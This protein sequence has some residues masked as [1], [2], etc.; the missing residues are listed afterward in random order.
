MHYRHLRK[1]VKYHDLSK[2]KV[3]ISREGKVLYSLPKEDFEI[4]YFIRQGKRVIEN[5]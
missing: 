1:G 5:R 2:T 4:H 3:P